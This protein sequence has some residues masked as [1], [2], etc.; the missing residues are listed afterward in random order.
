MADGYPVSTRFDCSTQAPQ[1][2]IEQTVT[3]GQSSL[4][5]GK[6]PVHLRL[7]DRQGVGR[8]VP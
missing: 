1:E 5:Y 7:E 8:N 6:Q 4:S 2:D 3:A